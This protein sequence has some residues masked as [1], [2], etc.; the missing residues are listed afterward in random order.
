VRAGSR[1]TRSVAAPLISAADEGKRSR[2]LTLEEESRLLAACDDP[3][4]SHLRAMIVC[5]ID[6]GMRRGEIL[7]LRWRDVDFISNVITILAL[8]TKTLTSRFVHMTPRLH[9]E[10]E[11]IG[12]AD[13]DARVF[14]VTHTVKRSFTTARKKAG[15]LDVRFHDLRHTAA[16]RLVRGGMSIAEVAGLLGHTQLTTTKRYLNADQQSRERAAHI[17]SRNEEVILG[18]ANAVDVIN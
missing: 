18:S 4:R 10:L 9:T 3:R 7:K 17:L 16:T 11:A 1:E 5:A 14:G 8:N 13:P 2:I 6:T 15:L 12:P